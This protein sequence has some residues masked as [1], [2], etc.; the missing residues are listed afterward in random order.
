MKLYIIPA[1]YPQ[2][3]QDIT[4]IFFRQQAQ[5]LAQRGH[6]VTV[7]HIEPLSVTWV[8]R[9]P[10]HNK[11]VWQ[12]GKVRTIYHKVIIPIPGKLADMQDKHIS[13]LYYDIIRKQILADEKEGLGKPDILH[14]HVSHSCAYYCLKVADK[15]KLPLVVTEHYSGLLLGTATEREY[16]R[17]KETIEK[18]DS[19][20]FVGSNFQKTICG[21]L[22]IEKDTCVI[23][24]MVEGSL[25]KEDVKNEK[26]QTKFTFLVACHMKK[27]KSVNLVIQAFHEAFAKDDN[28]R[29][30]VAGEGEELQ[31][32]R[33]LV[34][35]LGEESRIQF[36]GKYSREESKAIFSSANAFVLTSQVEPFGIVYIE[37]MA[38]GLPCIG[39]KGQGADDI[40]DETNGLLVPHGDVEELAIAMKKLYENKEMYDSEMIR[41]CCAKKFSENTICQML[42]KVY[43]GKR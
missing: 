8:L 20:I 10:W 42:E 23:P 14:A 30:V 15:L 6:E 38:S 36:Y 18:S 29:L 17:V 16:W 3:E 25:F 11:R 26:Q 4:A 41:E 19:F 37:A 21:K 12:D 5:A 1:W 2:D 24:N 9:K 22:G 32:H 27:H 31:A 13:N 28:I 43:L 7:L 33:K 40:I 39:T 34:V 35:E